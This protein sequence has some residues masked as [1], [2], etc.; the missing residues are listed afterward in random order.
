MTDAPIDAPPIDWSSFLPDILVAV[1]TGLLVGLALYI[2]EWSRRRAETRT[3]TLSGWLMVAPR[4]ER[5][6]W[7]PI[8]RNTASYI[9]LGSTI[10]RVRD[11]SDGYPLELW[12]QTLDRDDL[13]ALFELLSDYDALEASSEM[14]EGQ[15]QSALYLK[16]ITSD[17]GGM[18]GIMAR[19]QTFAR[20]DEELLAQFD[21]PNEF[22][23]KFIP[24]ALSLREHP[25]YEKAEQSLMG[26]HI[27]VA[28]AS[29]KFISAVRLARAEAF[30]LEAD[31]DHA[32]MVRR[33]F[34]RHPI[35]TVKRE[36][37][38]RRMRR[39]HGMAP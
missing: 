28:D 39:E 37:H 15:L 38:N 25:A 18:V 5:I 32:R 33:D 34:L 36:R 31:R 2:F 1:L 8:P 16:G 27:R 20:D 22:M 17:I 7:R 14:A 21:G 3:Q 19:A 23:R 24:L 11:I 10:Q 4:L 9:D 12:Q 26:V 6:I 30:Q 13:R 29:V 35:K